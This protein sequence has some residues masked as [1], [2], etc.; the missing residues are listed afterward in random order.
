MPVEILLCAHDDGK[1]RRRRR[2]THTADAR[3]ERRVPHPA[4]PVPRERHDGPVALL[5]LN[6]RLRPARRPPPPHIQ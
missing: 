5:S 4:L 3:I 1:H 6:R 2:S